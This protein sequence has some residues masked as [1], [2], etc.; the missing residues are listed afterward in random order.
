MR[1]EVEKQCN[2]ECVGVN[3]DEMPGRGCSHMA[4]THGLTLDAATEGM[5]RAAALDI[6]AA[7][8]MCPAECRRRVDRIVNRTDR[9]VK[10]MRR[11]MLCGT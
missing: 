5:G 1:G 7:A 11:L 3:V 4:R 2:E 6:E 10:A 9:L 8:L